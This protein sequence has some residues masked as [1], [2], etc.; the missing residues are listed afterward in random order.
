MVQKAG[1][2]HLFGSGGEGI[3]FTG[4]VY[5]FAPS[6]LTDGGGEEPTL[7]QTPQGGRLASRHRSRPGTRAM[8]A[9]STTAKALMTSASRRRGLTSSGSASRPMRHGYKGRRVGRGRSTRLSSSRNTSLGRASGPGCRSGRSQCRLRHT[10]GSPEC[11]G[12][13]R[14]HRNWQ[15]S[16]FSIGHWEN[17]SSNRHV[18]TVQVDTVHG[19]RALPVSCGVDHRV[20]H[21]SVSR[22]LGTSAPPAVGREGGQSAARGRGPGLQPSH[23]H[24]LDG[25][26]LQVL[27]HTGT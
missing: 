23:Q 4:S 19:R 7:T 8:S 11:A 27:A 21:A 20:W 9:K 24:V 18:H 2:L 17:S 16:G 25:V 13:R 3:Y 10:G 12:S 15:G 5:V 6:T 14:V 26:A 1:G 22:G